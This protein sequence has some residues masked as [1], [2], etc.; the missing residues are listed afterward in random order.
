MDAL[1]P[2]VLNC[3]WESSAVCGNSQLLPVDAGILY[4]DGGVLP[5]S[6]L[7]CLHGSRCLTAGTDWDS[8]GPRRPTQ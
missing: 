4:S 7:C 5:D 2:N 1:L 6:V 8:S 3:S